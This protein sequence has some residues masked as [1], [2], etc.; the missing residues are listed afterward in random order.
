MFNKKLAKLITIAILVSSCCAV[1]SANNIEDL[2]GNVILPTGDGNTNDGDFYFSTPTVDGSNCPAISELSVMSGNITVNYIEDDNNNKT[3]TPAP[4]NIR[5][6][7]IANLTKK[8]ISKDIT[9]YIEDINPYINATFSNLSFLDSRTNDCTIQ[10]DMTITCNKNL[11]SAGYNLIAGAQNNKA[12]IKSHAVGILTQKK[13][14]G[15]GKNVDDDAQYNMSIIVTEPKYITIP[16]ASLLE[17]TPDLSTPTNTSKFLEQLLYPQQTTNTVS[18]ENCPYAEQVG[19]D[20]YLPN[21]EESANDNWPF[22]S[23]YPDINKVTPSTDNTCIMRYN[24]FVPQKLDLTYSVSSSTDLQAAIDGATEGQQLDTTKIASCFKPSQMQINNAP[25]NQT[26]PIIITYANDIFNITTPTSTAASNTATYSTFRYKP[27]WWDINTTPS[28]GIDPNTP[29][30]TE[31]ATDIT[32][33][34]TNTSSIIADHAAVSAHWG[35]GLL[36]SRNY[37]RRNDGNDTEYYNFTANSAPVLEQTDAARAALKK[38]SPQN[39]TSITAKNFGGILNETCANNKLYDNSTGLLYNRPKLNCLIGIGSDSNN[40]SQDLANATL[41]QSYIINEPVKYIDLRI[42]SLLYD[43]SKFNPQDSTTWDN[44]NYLAYDKITVSIDHDPV[45]TGIT[46]NKD[47]SESLVIENNES[48]TT[49]SFAEENAT[50]L[51][52]ELQQNPANKNSACPVVTNNS[53]NTGTMPTGIPCQYQLV[54]TN[55][56]GQDNPVNIQRVTDISITYQ[57]KT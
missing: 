43:A 11:A 24:Y 5:C 2:F 16:Q 12:L 42:P 47:G 14:N 33:Q 46:H 26:R 4:K 17:L 32:T 34:H 31:T 18:L 45:S 39:I 15:I 29:L 23:R 49:Y 48:D 41:G 35:F 30:Y 22:H 52:F 38:T 20:Q 57:P 37:F 3:T 53:I 56:V 25:R 19:Q 54:L 51:K 13:F 50:G 27:K 9:L 55:S 44:Y 40:Y 28:G 36:I 8:D 1:F 10:K 21:T 7:Y 6:N